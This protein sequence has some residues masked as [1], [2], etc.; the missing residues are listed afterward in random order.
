MKVILEVWGVTSHQILA[1]RSS[2]VPSMGP[3]TK[4]LRPSAVA[5]RVSVANNKM[6]VILFIVA[7][8]LKAARYKKKHYPDM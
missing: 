3:E 6:N 1:E 5:S 2:M 4:A 7:A 8:V